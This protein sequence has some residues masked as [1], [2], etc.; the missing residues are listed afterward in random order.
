VQSG[1]GVGHHFYPVV[2]YSGEWQ[3]PAFATVQKTQGLIQQNTAGG[4]KLTVRYKPQEPS[5]DMLDV[6]PG[7][8]ISKDT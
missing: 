8:R 4:A 3:V 6:D 1:T 7:L 2:L 5:F